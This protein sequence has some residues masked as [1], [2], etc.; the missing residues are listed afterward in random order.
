MIGSNHRLAAIG[1]YLFVAAV[2]EQD[3]VPTANLS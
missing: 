2:V 3:Y 1:S